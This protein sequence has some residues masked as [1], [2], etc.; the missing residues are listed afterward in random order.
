MKLYDERRPW[1]LE[2][3]YGNHVQQMTAEGL[4]NKSDIAAELACRDCEIDRLRAELDQLK[5]GRGEP[6]AV[7]FV[8][9]CSGLQH[10][11]PGA[12]GQVSAVIVNGDRY[13]LPVPET[14]PAPER[15]IYLATEEMH[16]A[17]ADAQEG[18]TFSPPEWAQIVLSMPSAPA[19]AAVPTGWKLVPVE[20]TD[21]QEAKGW[22][23]GHPRRIY[24]LMLA[25]APQP[26][27]PES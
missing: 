13:E 15:L 1:E 23:S 19:P 14:E 21:A 27:D 5:Q 17:A 8:A 22:G 4:H 24:K 16:D 18:G 11:S 10:F 25:A 26:E 6:A 2:P 20:P 9:A 7:R 3:H 12:C